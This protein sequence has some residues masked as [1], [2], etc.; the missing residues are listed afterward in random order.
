MKTYLL[1]VFS[2]TAIFT[3]LFN[4]FAFGQTEQNNQAEAQIN[5]LTNRSGAYF[6]SGLNALQDGMRQQ[7][8]ENFDKSLEDFLYSTIAEY[9]FAFHHLRLEYFKRNGGQC[10]QIGFDRADYWN[11]Q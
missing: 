7:A 6:K 11:E 2:F 5:D 9:S 8:G 3:F 1:K 4:S 10:C